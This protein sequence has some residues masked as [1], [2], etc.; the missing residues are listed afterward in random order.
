MTTFCCGVYIINGQNNFTLVWP[1]RHK[2]E[3]NQLSNC[4]LKI[5][6]NE[7]SSQS[8][9]Q[10]ENDWFLSLSLDDVSACAISAGSGKIKQKDIFFLPF[11]HDCRKRARKKPP[12]PWRWPKGSIYTSIT[13][14]KNDYVRKCSIMPMLPPTSDMSYFQQ[15]LLKGIVQP[16]ELGGVTS[17]I[18]SAVRFC[19]A[20]HLNKKILMIQSH[21]RS[22]KP[23]SAA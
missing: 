8:F 14:E 22:L 6:I 3:Q 9:D 18:R 10:R 16:F 4:L 19:K 21:E 5:V 13:K 17:L 15:R 1:T 2:R 7:K 12:P 11:R 20:G 23:I